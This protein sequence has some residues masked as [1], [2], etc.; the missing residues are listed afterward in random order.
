MSL[1][2]PVPSSLRRLCCAA[3]AALAACCAHAQ[4]PTLVPSPASSPVNPEAAGL[5]H[6]GT[7][8]AGHGDYASAEIAYRQILERAEFPV[9]DQKTALLGLAHM[10]RKAGA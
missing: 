1:P 6:L 4:P 8:F 10:Y 2:R 3:G 5:I 7:N 9:S